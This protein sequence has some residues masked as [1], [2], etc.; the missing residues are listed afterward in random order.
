MDAGQSDDTPKELNTAGRRALYNSLMVPAAPKYPNAVADA[1]PGNY[2]A[3]DL[4]LRLDAAVK[5]HRPDGW[6]GVYAKEQ[7]IKAAMFDVLKDAEQVERLF[8]IV[9]R[10]REY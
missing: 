6:R 7:A 4:A 1:G 8:P 2:G 3:L 5:M 9:K 10:Q